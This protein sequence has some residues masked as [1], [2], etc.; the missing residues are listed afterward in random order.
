MIDENK[1]K[2]D[3]DVDVLVLP[4]LQ[5]NRRGRS[6]DLSADDLQ[7]DLFAHADL[8]RWPGLEADSGLCVTRKQGMFDYTEHL[9][10][11]SL[12]LIDLIWENHEVEPDRAKELLETLRREI[13]TRLSRLDQ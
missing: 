4:F 10:R 2:K 13:D 12:D 9:A 11:M 6:G 3:K 7:V 1:S 5:E 8:V